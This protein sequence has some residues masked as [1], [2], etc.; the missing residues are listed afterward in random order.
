MLE[1]FCFRIPNVVYHP[2]SHA[3]S[4]YIPFGRKHGLFVFV[5]LG[6]KITLKSHPE[7]QKSKTPF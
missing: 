3:L 5:W 7:K 6:K 1:K 2:V 4:L